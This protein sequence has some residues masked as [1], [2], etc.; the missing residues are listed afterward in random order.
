VYVVPKSIA[1][2]TEILLDHLKFV[3]AGTALAT[4]KHEKLI[5]EHAAALAIAIE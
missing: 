5:P 2:E 3:Q 4:M 1:K